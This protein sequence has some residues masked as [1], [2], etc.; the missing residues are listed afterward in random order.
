[1]SAKVTFTKLGLKKKDEIKTITLNNQV[2]EIKQYLPVE[3]KINII[4]NVLRESADD[5]NFANPIK[6]EVY[7]NL[8]IIYAYTNIN[9]TDKQKEDAAKLYDVL[10]ENGIFSVIIEQIPEMEYSLLL[11]WIDETISAF[12]NYRNSVMGILEQVSAD[13]SNLDFDASQIQSKLADPE[14][15]ALLK[16]VLTKLG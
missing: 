3:D 11:Q 9:F 8:E 12:Y 15:L 6:V 7:T 14:N 10:E 13:Y 2:I 16:D 4:T 5:N 1:M